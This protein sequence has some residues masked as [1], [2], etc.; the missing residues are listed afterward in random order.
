LL[1]RGQRIEI[2]GL[3]PVVLEGDADRL[4]E[5]FL[6]LL[7][8]AVK[9]TAT[10]QQVSLALWRRGGLAEV[11]IHDNG[12][13]IAT[14]ELPRVFERFYRTG[15]ARARDPGGT[16]LGL[17]IARWIVEQHGGQLDLDSLPGRGTTATVRLPLKDGR[18]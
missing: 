15:P 17:P 6:V 10:D 3:E 8:N 5:L 14:D 13:G 16:G 2:G 18:D 12:V 4:K 1:A 9:Y 11:T 7:D